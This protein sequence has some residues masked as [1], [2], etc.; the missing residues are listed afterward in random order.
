MGQ[1]SPT[2]NCTGREA[3]QR[4]T[5]N[6]SLLAQKDVP[7]WPTEAKTRVSWG[8]LKNRGVTLPG[9]KGSHAPRSHVVKELCCP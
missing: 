8:I 3:E 6:C 5:Q 2:V 1:S 7:A 9:H 4:A